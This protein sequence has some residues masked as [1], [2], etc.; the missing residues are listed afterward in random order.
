MV[1]AAWVY[2]LMSSDR[3]D[4]CVYSCDAYIVLQMCCVYIYVR[5]CGWVCICSMLLFI[6]CSECCISMFL[7]LVSCFIYAP[8][9]VRQYKHTT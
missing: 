4:L 7:F 2:V 9:R 3:F 5:L 1:T 6:L 8:K